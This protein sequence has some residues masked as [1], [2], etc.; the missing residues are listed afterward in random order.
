VAFFFKGRL[1]SGPDRIFEKA[2]VG[3]HPFMNRPGRAGI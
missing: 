3:L 1:R 2:F